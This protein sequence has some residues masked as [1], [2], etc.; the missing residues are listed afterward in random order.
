MTFPACSQENQEENSALPSI[1]ESVSQ[2]NSASE[3]SNLQ[4]DGTYTGE[5]YQLTA[6]RNWKLQTEQDVV[7]LVSPDYPD[8]ADCITVVKT[9][10][11]PSFDEMTEETYKMGLDAMFDD[12]QIQSF[13]KT[14]MDERDAV[15]VAYTSSMDGVSQLVHQLIVDDEEDTVTFTMIS[16][17]ED[18][19]EWIEGVEQSIQMEE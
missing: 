11:D 18:A 5:G 15:R 14:A 3:P 10:K 17:S 12:V 1:S 6:P 4:T 16:E 19:S 2:Q 13:E 7:L 8:K 9:S